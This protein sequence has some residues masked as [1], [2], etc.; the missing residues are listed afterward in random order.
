MTP[1]KLILMRICDGENVVIGGIMQHIE[2]GGV[3]SGDS[4]CSLPAYS[5]PQDI[6]DVMREASYKL[7]FELGVVGLDEYPDGS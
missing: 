3:H 1:L 2:Q 4:A 7:A 5:L 6:Q